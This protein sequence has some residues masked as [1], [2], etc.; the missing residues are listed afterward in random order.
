MLNDPMLMD[1]LAQFEQE[2][3]VRVAPCQTRGVLPKAPVWVA[4]FCRPP[5]LHG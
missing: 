3:E 4:A 2:V 1:D 5:S